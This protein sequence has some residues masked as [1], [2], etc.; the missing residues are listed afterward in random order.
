M[1]K[2]EF[3]EAVA[4]EPHEYQMHPNNYVQIEDELMT[5]REAWDRNLIPTEEDFTETIVNYM[6][7]KN[8]DLQRL[9]NDD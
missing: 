3:I 1:T 8:P 2:K 9:F 6:I 7:Y 5:Y 4:K